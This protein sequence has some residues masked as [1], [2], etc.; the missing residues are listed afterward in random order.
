MAIPFYSLALFLVFVYFE[1]SIWLPEIAQYRVALVIAGASLLLA[2]AKSGRIPKA[3]QN[4][5][6]VLLLGSAT[7]STTYSVSVET[8]QDRLIDLYKVICLYALIVMIVQT[9][10]YVRKLVIVILSYATVTTI[11]T[12]IASKLDIFLPGYK[13]IYR[14][15]SVFG[16][17]GDGP[18]E[19]GALL[20]GLLPLPLAMLEKEKSWPKR[21][22]LIIV[23]VSFLLCITRSRSRG[24]FVGMLIVL[25]FFVWDYRK[26]LGTIALF[27][28]LIGVTFL[29]TH[30]GYWERIGTLESEES[31]MEDGAV[32]GRALQ[33]GYAIDLMALRPLTGVGMDAFVS[34]KVQL[35]HMDPDDEVTKHVPHNAYLGIGAEIGAPAMIAFLLLIGVSILQCYSSEWSFRECEEHFG[36]YRIAKGIRIGLIGFGVCIFFLSEQYNSVLYQLIALTVAVRKIAIDIAESDSLHKAKNRD[37]DSAVAACSRAR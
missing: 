24:A 14:L 10:E 11:G 34:A 1:P 13:N 21:T 15:V 7:I 16:G 19:F 3:V 5:L 2:V 36:L 12:L 28:T 6:F 31:A 26:H 8:S 25:A 22:V 20:V 4:R 37:M 23:A 18:N 29:N 32:R 35:L 17:I 30:Y 33:I 9:E 27:T